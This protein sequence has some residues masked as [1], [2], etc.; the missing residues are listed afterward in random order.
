MNITRR[1]IISAALV[2]TVGTGGL[3]F[4]RPWAGRQPTALPTP[5]DQIIAETPATSSP[6]LPQPVAEP[7]SATV[8][9]EQ[10]TVATG[11]EPARGPIAP[12]AEP[13]ENR[14]SE[15]P[16]R[17]GSPSRLASQ[18]LNAWVLDALDDY[19]DGSYPY[20]LNTDYANYN[21][22]T[23]NISYKNALIAKA[24]P[25]GNRAS[26]CTGITFEVFFKAMQSRNRDLSVAIDDF[27]GMSV[28][29]LRSFMQ[30]WYVAG[31][32]SSNNLAIA[33]E[34]YGVGQRIHDLADAKAGDFIDFS[35][36]NGTGHTAVLIN[37][38][39]QNGEIIGFKYWS[40][41]GSTGGISY[42]TEYFTP[43]GSVMKSPVY[44]A[45]VG[46]ISD[47]R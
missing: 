38:I 33:V 26:H 20:L 45:R 7:Q 10:A 1:S 8:V 6:S 29:D 12:P 42:N 19:Q 21:G 11:T 14:P 46:S 16:N 3:L 40:S 41:Q 25:S 24:H 27:N 37:W 43:K 18:D 9:A 47:Y 23:R 13:I 15:L 31:P 34:R 32:K 22:V 28:S 30:L 2:F 4:A 5:A 39:Q 17:G 36:T 35:R 44:I